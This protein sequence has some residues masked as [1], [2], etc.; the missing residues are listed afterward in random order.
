[1]V[2]GFLAWPRQIVRLHPTDAQ[3][4]PDT[5]GL[6]DRL[7]YGVSHVRERAHPTSLD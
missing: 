5:P 1:M 7:P 2:A 6:G 4:S 3:F